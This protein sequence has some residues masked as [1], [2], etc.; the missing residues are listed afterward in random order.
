MS[1]GNIA[2]VYDK[3]GEVSISIED[4]EIP[5]PG[6]GQV[7]VEISHSGVCHSDYHLMTNDWPWMAGAVVPGRVG[8][9]EGVGIVRKLG[10]GVVAV[11]EG[12]SVGIKWLAGVCLSCELCLAGK[13]PW[14]ASQQVS[15]GNVD[16]TFQRY[17]LQDAKYLTPIPAGCRPEEA[18][19]M[20][21]AGVTIYAAI[22]KCKLPP[23]AWLAI[24]G[25]GGGLGHLGI[26]FGRAMG[27]RVVAI[28]G[29]SEKEK[30]C[31]SLGAEVFIDFT[32]T[33]DVPAAVTQATDGLGANAVVVANAAASAYKAAPQLVRLGGTVMC[34]GIP[35]QPTP[36]DVDAASVILKDLHIGGSAVGTRIEAIECMA[37]LARG[38]VKP[39]IKVHKLNDL[40]Q[41]FQDMAKGEIAGRTVVEISA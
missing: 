1:K 40:A 5:S 23:G 29:G 24:S 36:L 4:R 11:K 8:G 38:Q 25:A 14:C 20:L 27:L 39:I 17:S 41:I 28:D 35:G 31:K 33:Q 26:Q 7:L 37:Y 2:A 10:E 3:P 6:H 16:G 13:D 30:L 19:V 12:D 18:S 9:H 21:C 15:G 34:V 32:K 22:K